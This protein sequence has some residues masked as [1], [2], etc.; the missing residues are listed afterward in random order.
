MLS[1]VNMVNLAELFVVLQKE[2]MISFLDLHLTE[3]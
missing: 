2:L 1:V 3:K